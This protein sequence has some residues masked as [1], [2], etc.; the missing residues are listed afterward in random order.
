MRLFR[1][2]SIA[3]VALVAACASDS[4]L[5]PDDLR[6]PIDL[7]SSA[8]IEP[9]LNGQLQT[10]VSVVENRVYTRMTVTNGLTESVSSGACASATDARPA[11]GGAWLNVAPSVVTCTLQLIGA[12][13]GGN[14]WLSVVADRDMLRA[15]AGGP[16]RTVLMRVR[17][18]VWGAS[19]QYTVQSAEQIVTAP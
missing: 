4:I 14:M 15:V 6:P 5:G 9:R 8:A 16:G 19:A 11:A 17:H 3:A 12:A 13:P 2:L 10:P 7:R 1:H 18:V